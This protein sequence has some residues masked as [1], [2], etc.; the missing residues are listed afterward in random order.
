MINADIYKRILDVFQRCDVYQFPIDCFDILQTYEYS[1]KKYSELTPKKL[2]ACMELSEDAS[3][4]E[5]TVFYNDAK[6]Y[7]R[8]RFSLMHELGHIILHTD[9]E[10]LANHFSSNILAP[11]IAIHYSECKNAVDVMKY[12]ELSE[13]AS[14]Y[15]FNDYRKWLREVKIKGMGEADKHIYN[16]FFE[17]EINKFVWKKI[18]CDYCYNDYAY[19]GDVL[20]KSCTLFTLRKQFSTIKTVDPFDEEL[21][22]Q[23]GTRL[24]GEE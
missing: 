21:D 4:I 7:S 10:L 16:H 14:N 8:I 17:K 1:V 20:C 5:R 3:I 12:F 18:K 9:N 13:E 22:L 6:P 15:A 19:N 2:Q 24:F 23:R 11:R